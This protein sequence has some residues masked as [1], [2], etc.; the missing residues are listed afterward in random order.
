[1][2]V[3]KIPENFAFYISLHRD[4]NER[5]L[6]RAGQISSAELEVSLNRQDLRMK[7]MVR[8]VMG[9][10]HCMKAFVRLS[11]EGRC[12]LCGF[13]R[14]RHRIGE[15][16]CDHLARRNAGMVVVLGNSSESWISLFEDGRIWR[17]RGRGL[18]QTL[19]RLKK[20]P[21]GSD[22]GK[23]NRREERMSAE[24]F[25]QTYYDSQYCPERRNLPA[26]R[27]NMPRRDQEEAGLRLVQNRKNATLDDFLGQ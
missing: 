9:E 14:P 16:I 8:E 3:L 22:D 26:F 23:E 7:K 19:E 17:A 27:K 6:A 4:C 11:A 15:H 21:Q 1:V 12:I 24:C 13:C 2:A 25:W 5:L 20:A 10:M 18:E